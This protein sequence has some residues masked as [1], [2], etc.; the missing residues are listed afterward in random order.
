MQTS[1]PSWAPSLVW[2]IRI[3]LWLGV[4]AFGI[5]QVTSFG[6]PTPYAN[7]IQSLQD[8]WLSFLS[9]DIL[10]R[11]GAIWKIIAGLLLLLGFKTRIWAWLTLLLVIFAVIA[12]GP[13]PLTIIFG[14]LAWFIKFAGS[15]KRAMQQ[16]SIWC[17]WGMCC[18]WIC[19][20]KSGGC[21]C[22]NGSCAC[23][24]QK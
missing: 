22:K 4:L 12:D 3:L 7:S 23:D 5:M 18:G 11:L 2:I 16:E 20:S 19:G 9:Y 21:S 1:H 10:Y 13:I 17:A 6:D 14:L 15:G 24:I 8:Q